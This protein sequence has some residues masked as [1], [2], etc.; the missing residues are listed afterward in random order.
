[1]ID[2]VYC[3]CYAYSNV[4]VSATTIV[5]NCI[6]IYCYALKMARGVGL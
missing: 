4:S 6:T 2:D 5:A 1:M 3:S